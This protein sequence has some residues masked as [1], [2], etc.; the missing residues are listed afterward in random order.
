MIVPKTTEELLKK[1]EFKDVE[2]DPI[3]GIVTGYPKPQKY[4]KIIF[5]SPKVTL[6]NHYYYIIHFL[7]REKRFE[8]FEKITDV[9][10][11]ATMSAFF[12]NAMQRLAAQQ[13]RISNL[14]ANI[15]KLA[16]DILKQIQEL[17]KIDE[18]LGYFKAWKEKNRAADVALKGIW[19]DNVDSQGKM[20][21]SIFNL[22]TQRGYAALP[23]LFFRTAVWDEKEID[24]IV[25]NYDIS[26][27]LKSVLKRKLMNFLRWAKE[28]EHELEMRRRALLRMLAHNTNSI[29]LYA[30]WL[31]PYLWNTKFL[32]LHE[33]YMTSVYVVNSFDATVSEIE[34]LAKKRVGEKYDCALINFLYRTAPLMMSTTEY[35]KYP[36]HIGTIEITW[37]G[38]CWSQKEIENYKKMRDEE[39]LKLL[40]EIDD[41]IAKM[42]SNLGEDFEKYLKEAE[43]LDK[44]P[45]E[46]KKSDN[47]VV[48]DD[49]GIKEIL[50]PFKA[51]VE[52]FV[53]LVKIFIPE[54]EK[55]EEKKKESKDESKIVEDLTDAYIKYKKWNKWFTF[56]V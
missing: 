23:D 34:I 39:N 12:G 9:Y 50:E 20:E 32:S 41:N 51:L 55:K 30:S 36:I 16:I 56:D 7:E 6:E 40:S 18:R 48:S 1:Y 35:Q 44:K 31:R 45:Q 27:P 53:D 19:A 2:K 22:A 3:N 5:T 49:F 38:Y 24:E 33:K 29:K 42:L 8:E 28:V 11:S 26:Q 17:R 52:G 15:G 10:S 46:E 13:D 25:D 4:F 43:N 47:K 21:L 14:M 37:R 54:E